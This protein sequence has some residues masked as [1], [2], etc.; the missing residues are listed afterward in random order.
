MHCC[1]INQFD[2]FMFPNLNAYLHVGLFC[3]MRQL[4]HWILHVSRYHDQD[5]TVLFSW[6]LHFLLTC[7]RLT[8][9]VKGSA[10][11]HRFNIIWEDC[12]AGGP[13]SVY[14]SQCW[15][16]S[17]PRQWHCQRGRITLISI[18]GRRWICCSSW[19]PIRRKWHL[20]KRPTVR[21]SKWMTRWKQWWGSQFLNYIKCLDENH[22]MMFQLI[23]V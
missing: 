12:T 20:K 6:C 1:S 22:E 18:K 14:G 9:L 16:N 13:S 7:C 4:Q 17:F 3:W 23:W 19:F 15:Q 11:G 5:V 10:R 2:Y 21:Q 8:S